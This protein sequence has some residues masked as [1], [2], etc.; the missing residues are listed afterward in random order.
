MP[1]AP[2]RYPL[3][4][5]MP[6][7]QRLPD[8]AKL[9]TLSALIYLVAG[10]ALENAD[11]GVVPTSLDQTRA[12]DAWDTA[13]SFRPLV[14]LAVMGYVAQR[15]VRAI[16][17]KRGLAPPEWRAFAAASSL[18]GVGLALVPIPTTV[19]LAYGP[20]V[21]EPNDRI[22]VTQAVAAGTGA[23]AMAVLALV[24]LVFAVR[25][26]IHLVQSLVGTVVWRG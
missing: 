11:D 8:F 16:V 9:G 4:W 21:L 2:A 5:L 23:L 19:I 13:W 7:A 20:L 12:I 17:A 24:G 1:A 18:L 26:G 22:G 3:A 6:W 10:Q 25:A 15:I 14:G